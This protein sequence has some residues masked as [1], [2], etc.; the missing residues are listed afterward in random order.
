[1]NPKQMNNTIVSTNLSKPSFL[2]SRWSV[3]MSSSV[4]S[5]IS[6]SAISASVPPSD[7][8]PIDVAAI[9]LTCCSAVIAGLVSASYLH[10]PSRDFMTSENY[11]FIVS[12]LHLTIWG[13]SLYLIMGVDHGLAVD[14]EG[15]IWD[16]N[17]YF[18]AWLAFSLSVSLVADLVTIDDRSGLVHCS[19]APNNVVRKGWIYVLVASIVLTAFS[20]G[21][22]LGGICKDNTH[23]DDR[24]CD[25]IYTTAILSGMGIVTAT[26]SFISNRYW[27]TNKLNDGS[28]ARYG[29]ILA[30]TSLLSSAANI[31][32]TSS[33][34]RINSSSGNLFFLC[35]ACFFL[36]LR[37][38]LRYV[39][40]FKS[41]SKDS[42]V[43]HYTGSVTT[44]RRSSFGSLDCEDELESQRSG[45]TILDGQSTNLRRIQ[46]QPKSPSDVAHLD[47]LPHHSNPPSETK[48]NR[49]SSLDSSRKNATTFNIG[50]WHAKLPIE[51]QSQNIPTKSNPPL[52]QQQNPQSQ[53]NLN[54]RSSNRSSDTSRNSSLNGRRNH[55]T[56]MNTSD[57]TLRRSQEWFNRSCQIGE[58]P[59]TLSPQVSESSLNHNGQQRQS[60]SPCSTKSYTSTSTCKGFV[61][62]STGDSVPLTLSPDFE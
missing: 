12:I 6:S 29:A 7:R 59:P 33:N 36:S 3:W 19:Y 40:V 5:I 45:V 4:S 2:S 55:H 1:M 56:R 38:C 20:L 37:L 30:F 46:S 61:S 34:G 14:K 23:Q 17:L 57:P 28:L 49:R 50:D 32:V 52:C 44:S 15:S 51:P 60:K 42:S 13:V 21:T 62:S 25:Y 35:W 47:A 54:K 26:F 58:G 48:L 10:G 31:P 9:S 16:A 11:E 41:T 18:S 27:Q 53:A 8:T 39:D 43:G 22:A 24:R